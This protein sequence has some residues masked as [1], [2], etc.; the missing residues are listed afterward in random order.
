METSIAST[1]GRVA[2]PRAVI[3]VVGAHHHPHELLDDVGVLVG[4]L[5]RGERAEAAAVAGQAVRRCRRGPRPSTTSCQ[6]AVALDHRRG[7]PVARVDEAGAEAALHA[8]HALARGLAGTS[9]AMTRAGRPRGRAEVDAAAHAAVGAR[10]LAVAR[11]GVRWFLRAER[12]GRARRDALAARGADRRGHEAVAGHADPAWRGHDRAARWRRSAGRRRRR[13]C[14][15]RTGCTPR[16]RA[17]RTT[18]SRR[19]G[20]DAA[21]A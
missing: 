7:D 11:V 17:R 5:G 18:W 19:P 2:E 1:D 8:E 14:S 4:G 12:A 13:P 9:S 16:G 21:A 3:D 15:G 20:R 10:R 6:A